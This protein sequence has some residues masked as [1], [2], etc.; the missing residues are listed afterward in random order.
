MRNREQFFF[1]GFWVQIPL[2]KKDTI[3]YGPQNPLSIGL[4]ARILSGK[5]LRDRKGIGMKWRIPFL[6]PFNF[7]VRQRMEITCKVA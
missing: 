6:I 3:R 7:I 5:E 4:M 2:F 1:G